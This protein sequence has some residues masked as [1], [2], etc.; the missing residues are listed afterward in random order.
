MV[1]LARNLD[2]LGSRF[3]T[4]WTAVFVTRL[5][6]APAWQMRTLVLLIC[7]H[8]SY[9]SPFPTAVFIIVVTGLLWW[10]HFP[11]LQTL[12]LLFRWTPVSVSDLPSFHHPSNQCSRG[13]A[14]R[15]GRRNRQHRVSLDA[16]S[17]VIQE[18]FGSI[19][20]LFCGTPHYSHAILYQIGDRAGCTRS[21]VS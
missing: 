13:D 16:L 15:K 9:C 10:A 6:Q 4:G 1:A 19:A 20:A 12:D 17:C 11:P 7:R 8:H 21:P 2:L 3:F 5:R 14:Y 18:F